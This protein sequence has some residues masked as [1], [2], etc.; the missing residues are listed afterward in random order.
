MRSYSHLAWCL[1]YGKRS[2]M[3]AAIRVLVLIFVPETSVALGKSIHLFMPP[4]IILY[5]RSHTMQDTVE[6]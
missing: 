6:N 1:I 2:K 5:W 3:A 4:A